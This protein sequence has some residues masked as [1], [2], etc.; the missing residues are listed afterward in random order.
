MEGARG[1]LCGERDQEQ[2]GAMIVWRKG[3]GVRV[4]G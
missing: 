4:E 1:K 3:K 2:A